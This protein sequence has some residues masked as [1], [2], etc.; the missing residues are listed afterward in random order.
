MIINDYGAPGYL[1]DAFTLPPDRART[2]ELRTLANRMY[3]ESGGDGMPMDAFDRGCNEYRQSFYMRPDAGRMSTPEMAE[4][5]YFLNTPEK[6][7]RERRAGLDA[8]TIRRDFPIFK[9]QVNGHPL[10]W[11][12]NS[13]TT[14]KPQCVID[15]VSRY[16]SDYNSNIHRGAHTL[17]KEATDAYEAARDK[18]RSFLN[19]AFG[20]EII[21]VRGT[22]EGINLVASTWG[23]ANIH[24]GDE[25]ILTEME[26]HSN[27][28]PWQILCEKTGAILKIAPIDDHGDLILE[29]YVR[30]FTPR[31]R[32]AAFTHVSNV[33]GTV[34][35]VRRL[36]DIAHFHGALVL[37]DGAQSTPHMPVDVQAMD[38][39]FFVFSGHKIYGPTGI[40]AL[41]GKKAL[42]EAMPPYQSGGG[43]IRSVSFEKSSYLNAPGKFEA[44]TGNIADAVGLG[45]A[46]DYLQGIG[47]ERIRQYEHALTGYLMG[48]MCR[49]P[50]V[51][52]YGTSRDKT[53]VVSFTVRDIDPAII[54]RFLDQRGIAIRAGHHCAQPVLRHFGVKSLARASIGLYNTFAELDAF[55][56]AI[57][58]LSGQALT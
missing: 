28:V 15:A 43:M 34:N 58:E 10:V 52:L 1:P 12:D 41:Y 6:K 36:A 30:Q 2:E 48:K 21:F 8:E 5:Y 46:V 40:G 47:L 23:A 25:I 35:P 4:Q 56:D 33:L 9:R 39:D 16:Y 7:N 18:V 51:V 14:Q 53:S 38:A 54:A 55:A 19:A 49:I 11:L 44:G 57:A 22:T 20:E 26:H 24:P 45:A 31:T 29:G 32:L 37:V 3:Q 42:L 50:G 27:I 13:A 17:A